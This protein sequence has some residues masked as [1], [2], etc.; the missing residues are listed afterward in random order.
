MSTPARRLRE[1]RAPAQD[2]PVGSDL[3]ALQDVSAAVE[4]G[5]GLP[6]I[7]RA[8]AGALEASL[9]VSDPTG[10]VLAVAARSPADEASLAADTSGVEVFALRMG[11]E[12][13]VRMRM[14]TRSLA[15]DPLVLTVLRTL[16]GGAVDRVRAPERAS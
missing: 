11:A 4:A 14:R 10:S 16:I 3:R 1:T 9:L 5:A 13:V 15:P 7:V 8:A 2:A 12:L 6:Q